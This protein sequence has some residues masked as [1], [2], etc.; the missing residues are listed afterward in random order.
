MGTEVGSI[1]Q[2]RRP[3]VRVSR[4]DG[5]DAFLA[6]VDTGFNGD[7]YMAESVARQLGFELRAGKTIVELADRRFQLIRHA[8]GTIR[9]LGGPRRV[10]VFVAPD[11]EQNR[12]LGPDEPVALLGTGLLSPN[13]LLL[14]FS[15]MTIEI[16]AQ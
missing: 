13:V 3:L 7:L 9:W 5:E 1:D 16:E 15:D 14:D 12:P 6:L 10:E 11:Q 8:K 4:A 2:R